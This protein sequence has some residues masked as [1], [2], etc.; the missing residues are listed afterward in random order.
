M[1]PPPPG[2]LAGWVITEAEFLGQRPRGRCR[3][4]QVG[5]IAGQGEV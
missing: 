4:G 1:K 3:T 5:S 2:K